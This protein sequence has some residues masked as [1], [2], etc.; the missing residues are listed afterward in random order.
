MSLVAGCAGQKPPE[1]PPITDD[2]TPPPPSEP[3]IP[4]DQPDAQTGLRPNEV[5]RVLILEY[6]EIG[7]K[8][9][10]WERQYDN[11]RKD[12]Q[13]LYDANFRL[14]PLQAALTGRIDLPRG[15]SPV[16]ITFDDADA[17][18]F[19]YITQNGQRIID[20]NCA[21]GILE[22]FARAHPDFGK[23]A[24]FYTYVVATP[25]RQK[26]SVADKLH[27]LVDNGYEIG[28]HTYTHA[29]LSK[30]TPD[31][32]Q[33]ELGKQVQY[34]QEIIP[35]YQV[36]SLALPYGSYPKDKAFLL[37]G[38]FAGATYHNTGILLVGAEPAPS[39][40]A[41]AFSP[42]AVPR[43]QAR[44]SELDKWLPYLESHPLDR[45]VSDGDPKTVTVPEQKA[46]K[47]NQASLAGAELV[48]YK[49]PQ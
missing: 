25:F 1:P 3:V 6:H 30:M 47:V 27:F 42:L 21:V 16:A 10:D 7:D 37:D 28:N 34:I 12:L 11:F 19:R 36:A 35:G 43:V 24:T 26:D 45:Y 22:D 38:T 18:Q 9:A 15:Y 2:P 13:R 48:T 49:L 41:T 8:E 29:N 39:P 40:F 33:T 4:P 32:I 31:A 23:A 44:D 46:D 14:V 17:G 20:P 5:G